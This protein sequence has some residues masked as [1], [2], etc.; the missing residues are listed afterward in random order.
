MAEGG[1]N[2]KK[3]DAGPKTGFGSVE[4]ESASAPKERDRGEGEGEATCPVAIGSGG[5]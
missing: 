4:K 2:D 3:A 1:G 5:P